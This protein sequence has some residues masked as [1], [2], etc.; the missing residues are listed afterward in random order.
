V[1]LEHFGVSMW[2]IIHCS[3]LNCESRHYGTAANIL[4]YQQ[5]VFPFNFFNHLLFEKISPTTIWA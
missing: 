4:F 3:I 1:S 2:F 5:K